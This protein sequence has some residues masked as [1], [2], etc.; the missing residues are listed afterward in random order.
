MIAHKKYRPT[1]STVTTL[2]LKQ[3]AIDYIAQ[4]EARARGNWASILMELAPNTLGPAIQARGKHGV[5]CPR[6]PS[7]DALRIF[8]RD[9]HEIGGVVCNTCGPKKVGLLSLSFFEDLSYFEAAKLVGDTLG[10]P[11]DDYKR[12]FTP[13]P[14][15]LRPVLVDTESPEKIKQRVEKLKSVYQG[16]H[17]I[18][19]GGDS[20]VTRYFRHRKLQS[21]FDD[22]PQ[23]LLEHP[24]LE[25]W[26]PKVKI[27][28]RG[29]VEMVNGRP[30]TSM[31]KVGTF[32]ALIAVVRNSA[33]KIVTLHR[34]Y[35]NQD[36]TNVLVADPQTGE[37]SKA[38][39]MMS[40]GRRDAITGSAVRLYPGDWRIGT[41]EG[42]ETALGARLLL[43]EQH[44]ISLPVWSTLNASLLSSFQPP[45]EVREVIVLADNDD[46]ERNRH[47]EANGMGVGEMS[48]NKFRARA[49]DRNVV[50]VVSPVVDQDWADEYVSSIEPAPRSELVI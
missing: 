20:P 24:G 9:F 2:D 38:K 46:P 23:D 17:P 35:L 1:N 44:G 48:A 25:L 7:K 42:V 32:P 18:D 6:H 28:A 37:L 16:S 29:Q 31:A 12:D 33:G 45:E 50:V 49:T 36:G 30:V 39:K 40:S 5:P 10:I 8:H 41:A 3:R 19:W 14:T 22:P 11:W 43:R 21:L 13:K 15:I 4:V 34:I 26:H 47:R 27:D